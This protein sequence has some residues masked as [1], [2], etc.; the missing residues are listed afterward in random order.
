MTYNGYP[1]RIPTTQLDDQVVDLLNIEARKI[2]ASALGTDW[3]FAFQVQDEM[4]S[5]LQFA[6]AQCIDNEG[7]Y[8]EVTA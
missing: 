6:F 2:A 3:N 1:N 8:E 5:R 7:F 4:D